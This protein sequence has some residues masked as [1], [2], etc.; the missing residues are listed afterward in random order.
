MSNNMSATAN[1]F[2]GSLKSLFKES[3]PKSVVSS[4]LSSK[5]TKNSRFNNLK[6]YLKG[7]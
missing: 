1:T 3:Y 6:K 5:K 4:A 7:K 2:S